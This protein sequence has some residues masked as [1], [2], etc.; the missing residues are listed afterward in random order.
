MTICTL[1]KL[2]NAAL[3]DVKCDYKSETWEFFTPYIC[4][5]QNNIDGILSEA[6]TANK[7][8]GTH[9]NGLNN[10]DVTCFYASDKNFQ[11]FPKDLDKIFNNLEGIVIA[12]ANIKEVHQSDLKPFPNLIHLGLHVNEIEVIEEDL[13]KNNPK[14]KMI[15][16]RHNK[17]KQIYSKVFDNLVFLEKLRLL[18]NQCIDKDS[19]LS[20]SSVIDTIKHVK[21]QC[22]IAE[23]VNIE[24]QI[25]ILENYVN[26]FTIDSYDANKT[27]FEENYE[28]VQTQIKDL[29]LPKTHELSVKLESIQNVKIPF[30]VSLFK[31]I[32]NLTQNSDEN[33]KSS[34]LNL[35][36]QFST[37]NDNFE[38]FKSEIYSDFQELFDN[39][40]EKFEK[41]EKN[42]VEKIN[43]MAK[44]LQLAQGQH[45]SMISDKIKNLE[46]GLNDF[47]LKCLEYHKYQNGHS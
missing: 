27:K 10:N 6:L 34:I 42:L 44:N 4:D 18:G 25:K 47:N 8:T 37:M 35:N 38:S 45:F 21:L 32:Q 19:Q 33:A 40:D 3:L 2:S 28:N 24:N 11:F 23:Q 5:M 43:D 16:L 31:E 7:A 41:I 17:I 1:L 15:S 26:N 9:T 12:N 20:S 36:Q 29:D 46:N 22:T 30:V 39:L 13:F 14:L